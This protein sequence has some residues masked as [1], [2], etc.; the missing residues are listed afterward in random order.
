[1]L[2]CLHIGGEVGSLDEWVLYLLSQSQHSLVLELLSSLFA[3]QQQ[4]CVLFS[5]L[6]SCLCTEGKE[7]TEKT[8]AE[9]P[10][11]AAEEAV[12]LSLMIKSLMVNVLTDTCA[13]TSAHTL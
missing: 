12:W 3:C 4:H 13:R 7:S 1:M 2:I 6:K 10:G 9:L 8:R 5:L 11:R